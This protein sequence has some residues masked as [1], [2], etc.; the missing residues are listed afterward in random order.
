MAIPIKS[1]NPWLTTGVFP[2]PERGQTVTAPGSRNQE[3]K[4]LTVEVT[5]WAINPSSFPFGK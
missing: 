1:G 3:L 5:N 2:S 4:S